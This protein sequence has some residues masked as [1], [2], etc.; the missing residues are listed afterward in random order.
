MTHMIGRDMYRQ[1]LFR[2]SIQRLVAAVAQVRVERQITGWVISSVRQQRLVA[3]VQVI[4]VQRVHRES[5]QTTG[6][7]RLRV[8]QI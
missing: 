3:V 4:A 2:V 6:R 8:Q 1:D 5:R 7:A